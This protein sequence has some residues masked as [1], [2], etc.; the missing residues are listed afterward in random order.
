MAVYSRNPLDYLAARCA[1]HFLKARVAEWIAVN[2]F[3]VSFVFAVLAAYLA[4]PLAS[5]S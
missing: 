2:L 1:Y 5:S 3:I 4:S